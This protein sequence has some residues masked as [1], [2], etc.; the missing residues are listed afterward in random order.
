MAHTSAP[1]PPLEC[2]ISAFGGLQDPEVSPAD[3][4]AWSV[5]TSAPFALRLLPGD[6]FFLHS[7][8][9]LLFGALTQELQQLIR[10]SIPA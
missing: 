8:Q 6:H 2:P 9:P 4:R 10:E 7:A 1:K 3:L 5:Q